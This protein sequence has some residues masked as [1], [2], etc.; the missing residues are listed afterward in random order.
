[1]FLESGGSFSSAKPGSDIGARSSLSKEKCFMEGRGVPESFLT[2]GA[3]LKTTLTLGKVIARGKG[4]L[5]GPSTFSP[6][7][8]SR[9]V[10]SDG[11]VGL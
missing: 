8:G 11:S 2:P 4:W 3:G 6:P 9:G 7:T 1:M 5:W 10:R